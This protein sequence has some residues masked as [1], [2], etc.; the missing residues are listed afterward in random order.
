MMMLVQLTR[1]VY[2]MMLVLYNTTC[3]YD[4]VGDTSVYDDVCV[5]DTACIQDDAGV[6]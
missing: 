5:V 6:V 3:V 2:R 4:H 1:H